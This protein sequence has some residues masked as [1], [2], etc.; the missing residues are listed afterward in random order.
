MQD[1]DATAEEAEAS[2]N[3]RAELIERAL[4][5]VKYLL[6]RLVLLISFGPGIL[7]LLWLLG[8]IFKKR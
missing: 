4:T 2:A 7:G 8:R 6:K 1:Y 5:F 3:Q